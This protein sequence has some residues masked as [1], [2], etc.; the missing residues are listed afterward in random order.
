MKGLKKRRGNPIVRK[1]TKCWSRT[2]FMDGHESDEDKS[3][4]NKKLLMRLK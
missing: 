2:E 3:I 4:G 1:L